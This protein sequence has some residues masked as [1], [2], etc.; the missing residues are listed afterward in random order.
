MA[1][2][3]YICVMVNSSGVLA[4]SDSTSN[5]TYAL[6]T[7]EQ[8]NSMVSTE[9]NFMSW[10]QFDATSA[11]IGFSACL[12]MWVLGVKLGAVIRTLFAARR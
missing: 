5:C 12:A 6:L 4:P 3:S 2:V 1:S 11:G 9:T 10:F 8:Y 7:V